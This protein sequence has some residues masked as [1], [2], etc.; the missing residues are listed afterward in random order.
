VTVVEQGPAQVGEVLLK[1][2]FLIQLAPAICR[3]LQNSMAEEEKSL[4]QKCS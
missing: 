3:K 1:G 4:N 2:K